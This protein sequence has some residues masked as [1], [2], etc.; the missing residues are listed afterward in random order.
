MVSAKQIPSAGTFV[1][2]ADSDVLAD[3][4]KSLA[5]LGTLEELEGSDLLLLRV[6]DAYPDPKSAWQ[7]ILD[8]AGSAQWVA[9]LLLDDRSHPHFPTGDVTVRFI[10]APSEAELGQFAQA[11]GLHLRGRNEFISEQASFTLAHPRR[12]YLPD[13]LQF[14]G[15]EEGVAA[16]WAN[17]LSHY[18]RKPADR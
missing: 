1:V 4:R 5:G 7:R 16:A 10:R 17:T 15:Q 2:K 6:G 12:T 8:R 18:R 9:P 13:L 14:L 3:V 11:H